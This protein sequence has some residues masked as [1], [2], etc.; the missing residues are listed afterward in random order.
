VRSRARFKEDVMD[1]Y[2]LLVVA[3]LPSL[4]IAVPCLIARVRA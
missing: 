1:I 4:G 2:L 3:A